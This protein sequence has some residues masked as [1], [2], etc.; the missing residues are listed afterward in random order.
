MNI[1]RKILL[2]LIFPS[3]L[4]SQTQNN[5]LEGQ[6]KV[7]FPNYQK[8]MYEYFDN[9]N[10][11]VITLNESGREFGLTSIGSTGEYSVSFS[12]DTCVEFRT[13]DYS[14][15]HYFRFDGDYAVSFSY[16]PI[17]Q[18]STLIH[19]YSL[20]VRNI[21]NPERKGTIICRK[22]RYIVPKGFS[23]IVA[24]EYGKP[25]G[26][27]PE[28]DQDGNIMLCV[29][30]SG[31]LKTTISPNVFCIALGEYQVELENGDGTY[32]QLEDLSSFADK[33]IT[34]DSM[35]YSGNKLFSRVY[36]F[37]PIGRK[38]L[39]KAFNDDFFGNVLLLGVGEFEVMRKNFFR[40]IQ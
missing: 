28:Y 27:E 38:E 34:L 2:L 21:P 8:E 33:N 6:W 37:N 20:W 1:I 9:G 31:I 5:P 26:V 25:D 40:I 11:K 18:T 30:Q 16:K 17:K 10:F 29:P 32:S 36:G 22:M 35:I 13:L 15:T 4:F 14:T 23:G 12:G 19:D 3:A 7:V 24:I 39:S